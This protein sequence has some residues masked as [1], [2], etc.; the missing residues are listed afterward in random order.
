MISPDYS[1]LAETALGLPEADRAELASLLL[2]SLDRHLPPSQRRSSA[3]WTAEIM[4]RSDAHHAG[5]AELVDAIDALQMMRSAI[6]TATK[7]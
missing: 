7:E 5:T 6:A 1:Q 2:Q 3:E 4:R